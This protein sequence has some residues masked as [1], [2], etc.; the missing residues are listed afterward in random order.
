[1]PGVG[2]RRARLNSPHPLRG[3]GGRENVKGCTIRASSITPG[4]VDEVQTVT[5]SGS[6][7]GGTFTLTYSGAATTAIAFNA[8][9]TAVE[10]ALEALS[11]IGNGNIRVTGSAGGPY[12]VTFLRDLGKQ[13]VAAM[14]ASGAS[15][16]GGTTPSVAVTTATAGSDTDAGL[17]LIRRGTIIKLDP[18]DS[19][20]AIPYDNSG[21]I[22]GVLAEDHIFM[23]RTSISDTDLSYYAGPNCDFVSNN[24]RGADG[25][26][27]TY[28]TNFATWAQTHGSIVTTN[29]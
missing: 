5:I 7:S 24:L 19:T 11:T 27:A 15:L 10:D 28:A 16:T 21:T 4:G 29:P 23:D 3:F 17:L 14:T 22:M 2:T 26:Y 13:N 8:A 18:T 20:K 1:M 25:T 12:T 6:P 9:A